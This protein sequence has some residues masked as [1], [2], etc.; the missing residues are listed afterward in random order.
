MDDE[1]YRCMR[2]CDEPHCADRREMDMTKDELKDTIKEAQ[3]EA[4][5]EHLAEQ[6]RKLEKITFKGVVSLIT[7]LLLYAVFSIAANLGVLQIA[8]KAQ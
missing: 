1:I 6:Q 5:K 7:A 8:G 4:L 3:K 2:T